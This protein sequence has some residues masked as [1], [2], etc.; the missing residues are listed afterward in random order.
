MGGR[1]MDGMG[2]CHGYVGISRH[3]HDA[4]NWC[5][6]L[7]FDLSNFPSLISYSAVRHSWLSQHSY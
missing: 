5:M 6:R 1:V 2:Q 7:S 4:S 3:V